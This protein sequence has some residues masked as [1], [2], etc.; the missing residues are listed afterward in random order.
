LSRLSGEQRRIQILEIAVAL[1]SARGYNGTSTRSIADAA[2]INEALIFRYFPTKLALFHAV[3]VKY[4][5]QA[6]QANMPELPEGATLPEVLTIRCTQFLDS[7]W[8]S[9][10]AFRML[11]S[12]ALNDEVANNDL[13]VL[14]ERL[15]QRLEGLLKQFDAS[16]G[17]KEGRVQ[18]TAE[19]ISF[20]L[21][22][23]VYVSIRDE[24]GNWEAV[25]AAFVENL[26]RVI[27]PGLLS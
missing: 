16:G 4:G 6:F 14:D 17:I 24:H 27:M 11:L 3:I 7:I 13:K 19:M 26:I 8:N 12:A 21:R 23:F 18:E 2:G 9:R 20:A 1:F 25:R 10:V 22:G 5:S 15:C